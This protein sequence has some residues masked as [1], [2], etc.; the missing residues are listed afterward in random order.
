MKTK[1]LAWKFFFFFSFFFKSW[2]KN[3]NSKKSIW[4]GGVEEDTCSYIVSTLKFGSISLYQILLS[5]EDKYLA[6]R[7]YYPNK[8]LSK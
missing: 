2:D 4:K 6:H 7:Q 8:M 5:G 1:K 3:K